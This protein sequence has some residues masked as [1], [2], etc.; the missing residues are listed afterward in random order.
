ML[1]QPPRAPHWR[2]LC[3]KPVQRWLRTGAARGPAL[4]A[5]GLR[6]PTPKSP[7][8]EWRVQIKL[9]QGNKAS[10]SYLQ[11]TLIPSASNTSVFYTD[12]YGDMIPQLLLVF[13]ANFNCLPFCGHT[14]P[15]F[16][17]LRINHRISPWPPTASSTR[18]PEVISG[19]LIYE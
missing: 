11:V 12:L 18:A 6:N 5:G 16:S 9:I 15:C 19:V 14:S 4:P 1:P 7:E 8:S 2:W 17:C 10:N 13:R 3:R